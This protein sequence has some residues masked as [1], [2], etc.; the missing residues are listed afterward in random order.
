MTGGDDVG[1]GEGLGEGRGGEVEAEDPGA[2]ED[3]ACGVGDAGRTDDIGDGDGNGVG[4]GDGAAPN[5]AT[6]AGRAQ[7]RAAFRRT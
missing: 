3:E 6:S 5:V 4:D 2:L 7:N 1:R